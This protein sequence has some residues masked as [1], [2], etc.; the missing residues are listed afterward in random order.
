MDGLTTG[1]AAAAKAAVS[2][3]IKVLST[4]SLNPIIY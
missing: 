4:F 3:H 2:N 1:K